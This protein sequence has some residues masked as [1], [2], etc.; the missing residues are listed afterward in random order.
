MT[1]KHL[2]YH[3]HFVF[4]PHL[5]LNFKT[6]IVTELNKHFIWEMENQ[7]IDLFNFLTYEV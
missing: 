7:F 1:L 2:L 3:P 5:E 4:T 6:F